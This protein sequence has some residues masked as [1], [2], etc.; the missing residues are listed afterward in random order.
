MTR[1]DF[2]RVRTKL[3]EGTSPRVTLLHPL[4]T[5]ADLDALLEAPGTADRW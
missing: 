3:P 5:D 1:G 4:T 2:T